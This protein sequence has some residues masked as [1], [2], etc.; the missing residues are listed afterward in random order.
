MPNPKNVHVT[1]DKD[2][3]QWKVKTEGASRAAGYYGTKAEAHSAGRQVAENKSGELFIHDK[4]N[5]QIK[6]RDSY[7][8][9]PYPPKG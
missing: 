4:K 2:N 6:E 7:G 3:D 8:N 1:F 5:G 9:D